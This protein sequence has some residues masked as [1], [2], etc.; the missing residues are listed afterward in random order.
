MLWFVIV[1]CAFLAIVLCFACMDY[2]FSMESEKGKMKVIGVALLIIFASLV[3]LK[4][5]EVKDTNNYVICFEN[6]VQYLSEIDHIN[7]LHKY[8]AFESGYL[9]CNALFYHLIP[10]FRF[11]FFVITLFSS[12]FS[13]KNLEE[14][15]QME[16]QNSDDHWFITMAIYMSG[17]AMSYLG[18][19][20]RA[21]FSM[22]FMLISYKYFCKKK[23]VAS[24]IFL[25]IGFT[26]HRSILCVALLMAMK[27]IGLKINKRFV[28][29]VY[30]ILLA[31]LFLNVGGWV[32]NY[33]AESAI[34]VLE[35][36]GMEEYAYYMM[37][38]L[39]QQVG[40][41]DI[42]VCLSGFI[43]CLLSDEKG[44]KS[45]NVLYFSFLTALVII[46]FLHGARAVARFY[47]IFLFFTIPIYAEI[48]YI[49]KK[50]PGIW[51]L[52]F[53]LIGNF[54]VS[55]KTVFL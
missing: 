3:A 49:L 55:M 25:L 17:Y 1:Y 54:M 30:I 12:F 10:N 27:I 50:K 13:I 8:H 9:L 31:M 7:F 21:G 47:E 51:V 40:L 41:T 32:Y 38:G 22:T 20:I 15:R 28:L 53:L 48:I 4:P 18:V 43:I 11:L 14:I 5:L 46:V 44:K 36:I 39:D 29:C 24:M 19:A 42:W 37:S 23:Y 6:S 35:K 33:I 26:I 2:G 52:L 34:P 45:F 16:F